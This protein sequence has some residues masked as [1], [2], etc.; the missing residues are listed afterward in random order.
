MKVSADVEYISAVETNSSQQALVGS[1]H[2]RLIT[3]KIDSDPYICIASH[4]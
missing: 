1:A 3:A 2:I 4:V